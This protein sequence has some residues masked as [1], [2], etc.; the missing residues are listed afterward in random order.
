MSDLAVKQ[1]GGALAAMPQ[2]MGV[3]EGGTAQDMTIPLAHLY[4]DTTQER[5][6]FGSGFNPGDLVNIITLQPI[7]ARRF[8]VLNG[9]IDYEDKRENAPTR[10]SRNPADW[11]DDDHKFLD[12][13]DNKKPH[14]AVTKRM[15]FA[16]LFEGEDW[17]VVLRFKKTS[18]G[19]GRNLNTMLT[20]Q[21]TKGTVGL[22]E[23]GTKEESGN[24]NTYI[25][26]VIKPC[27]QPASDLLGAASQLYA[28]INNV[29]VKVDEGDTTFN[30]DE[31]EQE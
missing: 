5:R 13:A 21:R 10:V 15:N 22:F 20:M 18:L 27:G 7:A 24:N 3:L 11:P 9:W 31:F 6:V 2:G 23:Y 17:P 26:P 28:M 12:R 16:V 19:A 14:P 25:V 30:P 8:V 29:E 4:Q 1:S